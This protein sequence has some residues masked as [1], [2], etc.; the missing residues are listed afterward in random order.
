MHGDEINSI[1][2]I[3][4][5]HTHR[6]LKHLR[7]TLITIP[8]ANVFGFILQIRYL[9]DRR[10]SNRSF[11]GSKMGLLA[12]RLANLL[13]EEIVTQCNYGID[14][15]TG[16][17]GH[18]NMP[19]LRVNLDTP[20][21]E[22]LAHAFDVPVILNAKIRDGSLREAASELGIPLLV[23]EAGEALRFNEICIR[24]G[25]RGIINVLKALDMLGTSK[26]K[27][28]VKYKSVIT[29]TSR[30]VRAT[31]VLVQTIAQVSQTVQKDDIL[32]YIHDPFFAKRI[33]RYSC[34]V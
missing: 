26:A 6:S 4:R 7:G 2:I 31:E 29:N 14:L 8:V 10:D 16:S 25:V 19:Q 23:Y 27:K 30:W 24:A 15:H 33:C 32:A 18:L 22:Q 9:P 5:L 21:A 34:A 3:R 28:P 1:E 12:A 20:G 17:I 13:I 11:P